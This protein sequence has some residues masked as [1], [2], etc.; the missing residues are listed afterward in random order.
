MSKGPSKNIAALSVSRSPIF[1]PCSLNNVRIFLWLTK[2]AWLLSLLPFFH[3]VSAV[4]FTPDISLNCS[5]KKRVIVNNA[6]IT[7]FFFKL[8]VFLF[9]FVFIYYISTAPLNCNK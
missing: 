7:S 5:R 9:C 1:F 6:R 2:N 4:Q 3:T 8:F